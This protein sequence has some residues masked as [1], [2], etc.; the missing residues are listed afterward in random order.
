MKRRL[1]VLFMLIGGIPL[2]LL[3]LYSYNILYDKTI[4]E[5]RLETQ[6]NLGIIQNGMRTLIEENMT[7]LQVLANNPTIMS[8]NAE[9]AKPILVSTQKA[10][11]QASI[12]LDNAVG[13]QI[14]VGDSRA[15]LNVADRDFFK[16]A[17]QNKQAISNVLLGRATNQLIV[18]LAVPITVGGKVAGVIQG[19]IFLDV[20]SEYTK[21]VSSEGTIAFI[22]DSEGKILAH[23]DDQK[24]KE[25]KDLSDT[26]FI[27]R[28]LK[29]ESGSSIIK[30]EHGWETI[31]YYSYD[32]FTGW[33]VCIETPKAKVMAGIN[34]FI[35]YF[36][37]GFLLIMICL[38]FIGW[39]LAR[40]VSQPLIV[41]R[42]KSRRV[43]SGDLSGTSLHINSHD[44][45][46][47]LGCAF[48]AMT[49]S[50]KRLVN[51]VAV[52][53]DQVTA[54][55]QQLSVSTEQ[56]SRAVEIVVSSIADISAGTEEQSQLVARALSKVDKNMNDIETA[57]ENAKNIL[58]CA[59]AAVMKSQNGSQA[60]LE[61]VN[62]MESIEKSVLD[63]AKTIQK[64]DKES[65]QI[66]EVTTAISAIVAQTNLLALNAAIEAAKAGESG[67]GFAVVADEVKKLAEQSQNSLGE[68]KT[69][70]EHIQ[71]NVQQSVNAMQQGT[72]EVASGRSVINTAGEA[73]KDIKDTIYIVAEKLQDMSSVMEKL[74]QENSMV[75]TTFTH[76]KQISTTTA[77]NTQNVSASVEEQLA[78]MQEM[79]ALGKVLADMAE[80]LKV[81]VSMFKV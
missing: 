64:L 55:S 9:A 68:I 8:F 60:V 26:T 41:L 37:A 1:M 40:K 44:E 52:S 16:N 39:S 25:R 7:V 3:A 74:V 65:R 10:F 42:E 66:E 13:M 19:S 5:Y 70:I 76:I 81:D 2:L 51:G 34:K 29:G 56:S 75:S 28:G 47:E 67:R 20:L 57:A 6:N 22:V 32:E 15:P 72:L 73:F 69:L 12:S 23:P 59:D 50:L 53:A 38:S 43:A 11:P 17:M 27:Q 46:G 30:D 21:K 54:S 80:K 49:N 35:S 79:A 4:R 45:I 61:A 14:A 77:E 71:M 63:T 18:V 31:V 58:T 33:L 24:V 48:D 36:V 78:T 62:R